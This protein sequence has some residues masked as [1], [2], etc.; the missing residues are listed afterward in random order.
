M[1]IIKCDR[2]GKEIPNGTRIGYIAM[3]WRAPSDDSLLED[4][5]YERMD[6]CPACMETIV[7]V[8]DCGIEEA[9]EEEPEAVEESPEAVEEDEADEDPDE[10]EAEEPE[11]EPAPTP[12]PVSRRK[13]VNYSKLRELVKKDLSNEEIAREL[14]ITMKQFYYARK[15]TEQLYVA[16]EI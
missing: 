13:G 9:V 2:C 4:N 11:P 5:P 14:G 15:R 16:G 8:I 1:R 12:K 3:N 10:D 7:K 6:F